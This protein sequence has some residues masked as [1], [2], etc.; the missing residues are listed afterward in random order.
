VTEPTPEQPQITATVSPAEP[1][2]SRWGAI[3]HHLGRART[4]TV[5]LSLLFLAVGALWLNVR[6]DPDV[7]APASGG[8]AVVDQPA[9]PTTAVPT[10]PAPTTEPL[11]TTSEVPTTTTEPEPTTSSPEVPAPTET[12]TDSPVTTTATEAPSP[13]PGT[14]STPT[15]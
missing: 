9:A 1:P 14:T 12:G 6:P 11:P 7:P 13:R 3:P 10:T 8:G 5:V 2:R 15:G 4:S